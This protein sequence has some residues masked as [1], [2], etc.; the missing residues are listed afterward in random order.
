M[1]IRT[2]RSPEKKG[3]PCSHNKQ[4]DL[5][6]KVRFVKKNILNYQMSKSYIHKTTSE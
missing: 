5:D 3:M 2:T 4:N 1:A 6:K